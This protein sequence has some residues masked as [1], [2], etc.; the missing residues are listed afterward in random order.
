M[1]TF[2]F[3]DQ[4]QKMPLS[5]GTILALGIGLRDSRPISLFPTEFLTLM[6]WVL[7][8]YTQTR[9][10]FIIS[11]NLDLILPCLEQEMASTSFLKDLDK[12][13]LVRE[14]SHNGLRISQLGH[15]QQLAMLKEGL[16]NR[17]GQGLCKCRYLTE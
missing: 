5:E 7:N 2:I 10:L 15:S 8:R 16:Q 11:L 12:I 14:I 1:R 3:V 17:T 6:E 13:L 9:V 4:P